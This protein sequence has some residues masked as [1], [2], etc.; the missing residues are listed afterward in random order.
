LREAGYQF[1]IFTSDEFLDD[2][3]WVEREVRRLARP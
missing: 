3:D 1:E 2:I